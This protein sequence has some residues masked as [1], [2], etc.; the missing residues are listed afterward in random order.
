LDHAETLCGCK[1]QAVVQQKKA[2]VYL[3]KSMPKE[4]VKQVEASAKSLSYGGEKKDEA[5]A[6]RLVADYYVNQ[7]KYD[8]AVEAAQRSKVIAQELKDPMLEVQAL[9]MLTTVHCERGEQAAAIQA[10]YEQRK[11]WNQAGFQD[12]EASVLLGIADFLG[13][14]NNVRGAKEAATDAAELF[15]A[16]GDQEGWASSYLT[17]A[18]LQMNARQW[19]E[20]LEST[21]E[22]RRIA[23][24]AGDALGEAD[25]LQ[26]AATVYSN[27]GNDVEA[28]KVAGEA[29]QLLMKAGE[30]RGEAKAW[31]LIGQLHLQACV[32][33]T[34]K[35]RRSVDMKVAKRAFDA[36][37]SCAR[38]YRE[39]DDLEGLSTAMQ[40]VSNAHY[41]LGEKEDALRTAQEALEAAE[42]LQSP[43]L[44]SSSLYSIAQAHVAMDALNEALAVAQDAVGISQQADD[45]QGHALAQ[46]LVAQLQEM[47]KPTNTISRFGGRAGFGG[48]GRGRGFGGRP[49]GADADSMEEQTAGGG[50][51]TGGRG[52][53]NPFERQRLQRQQVEADA[54]AQDQ[55]GRGTAGNGRGGAGFGGRGA[56]FGGFAAGRGRGVFGMPGGGAAAAPADAEPA[57]APQRTRRSGFSSFSSRQAASEEASN[58]NGRQPSR[59]APNPF[60]E[61]K[62]FGFTPE[63]RS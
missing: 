19:T 16:L 10:S 47:L 17:L 23:C 38:L 40:L 37:E 29:Q 59:A 49:L 48:R 28:G 57:E 44:V 9:Q 60:G 61:K 31:Q 51:G 20:A 53:M 56:G 24:N 25:A 63:G 34:E 5:S 32:Q 8:D 14:S 30:R 2:S 50:R 1:H 39:V 58:G 45:E 6:W 62:H 18:Q 27:Q 52:G 4:A 41:F 35:Q 42:A 3:A 43:Q 11:V 13:T 15:K 33:A 46:N 36:A 54:A 26:T 22:S 7:K 12:E 55:D 21:K